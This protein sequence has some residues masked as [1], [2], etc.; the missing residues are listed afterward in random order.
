MK[1]LVHIY[2]GDGKG[3]TS[4]ALG[5]AVRAAGR[6]LRVLIVRF[7]KNDDSGEVPVLGGIP[8]VTV[9]PC[10]RSFGFV[11]RMSEEE[12]QE[13]AIWFGGLFGDACERAVREDYDVLVCDEL[14]GACSLG[15]VDETA[16]L[17][18][19]QNRPEKLEVVLTGRGPSQKLLELADY[20]S[21]ITMRKH[22]YTAGVAAR[23][24]I[25][26]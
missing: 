17:D 2:C 9:L 3:K 7:L 18:F 5:L 24:G 1:G 11:F 8:G 13:A 10:A 26:Y 21:E 14:V 12:K 25:E 16:V 22:P 4:A 15:M 23:R 19:L 6:G 20:V